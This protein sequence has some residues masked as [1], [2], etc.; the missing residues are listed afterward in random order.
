MHFKI[1]AQRTKNDRPKISWSDTRTGLGQNK[2][3]LRTRSG[4]KIRKSRLNSGRSVR[5]ALILKWTLRI[6]FALTAKWKLS[7]IKSFGKS[8]GFAFWPSS[9]V[10]KSLI[11]DRKIGHITADGP[12]SGVSG[13]FLLTCIRIRNHHNVKRSFHKFLKLTLFEIPLHFE[14]H[15]A[16][17]ARLL[18]QF[19][20]WDAAD[21][22]HGRP[23]SRPSKKHF[24]NKES[25]Q[26]TWPNWDRNRLY[27]S[28]HNVNMNF[29]NLLE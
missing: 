7:L 29:H 3:K 10:L 13:K 15:P 26:R 2:S 21:R 24:L 9:V 14:F 11:T 18:F 23:C 1:R 5:G 20:N 16:L 19:T 22:T 6:I 8:I 17:F 4:L 27:N 12:P 28:F 25:R